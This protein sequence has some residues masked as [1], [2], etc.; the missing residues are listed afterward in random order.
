MID[1][2][3]NGALPT[4]VD[5]IQPNIS[6]DS[7]GKINWTPGYLDYNAS[8]YFPGKTVKSEEFNKHNLQH[9][10]QGNYITDVL[11]LIFDKHLPDSISK[12]F[13]SEFDLKPSFV[14]TFTA[15]DWGEEQEDG[16][17]YITVT[18]EEHGH[19]PDPMG[20]NTLER[21]N[22]DTEM[23][24]LNSDSRFYEVQQVTVD[25]DNTVHIYTDDPTLAGFLVVR[26]NDKAYALADVNIHVSQVIGVSEVAITGR[27]A[28]LVDLTKPDGTG[29]DDRI[30]ANTRDIASILSGIDNDNNVVKVAKALQADSA[31]EATAV[32]GTGTLGGRVINNIFE[33]G[34]NTVKKATN[35]DIVSDVSVAEDTVSFNIGTGRY[36]KKINNVANATA[37]NNLNIV[38]ENGVLNIDGII[39]PQKKVLWSDT[40]GVILNEEL[41]LIKTIFN[42]GTVYIGKHLR[43]KYAV[44]TKSISNGDATAEQVSYPIINYT[45]FIF[46]GHIATGDDVFTEHLAVV[47]LIKRYDNDDGF[48]TSGTHQ[49]GIIINSNGEFKAYV[50]GS[51]AIPHAVK[52][53]EV[54]EIIE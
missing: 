36:T 28:D 53:Y 9:V 40:N 42:I 48:Q 29:P 46:T 8:N 2:N 25:T 15:D 18:A 35:V 12:Q 10:Y 51:G 33:V 50:F 1:I 11:Q 38:E 37:V 13:R 22:I 6:V 27:Y 3:L 5:R 7:A 43:I 4:H 54:S 14:K 45:D 17:Y 23:Y 34:S 32:L 16:Y 39:I 52:L 24:L 26:T 31:N 41:D 30:T 21:M 20:E 19:A 49:L 47:D 44:G